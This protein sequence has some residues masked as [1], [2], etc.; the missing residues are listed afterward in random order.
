VTASK[1]YYIDSSCCNLHLISGLLASSIMSSSTKCQPATVQYWEPDN[2]RD[3]S[4]CGF[5][6]APPPKTITTKE[7]QLHDIRLEKIEPK[8]KTHGFQVIYHKSSLLGNGYSS[9]RF[10]DDNVENIYFPEVINLV[11]RELGPTQ[12]FIFNCGIR[13][14]PAPDTIV[15]TS[16]P[17]FKRDGPCGIPL[18]LDSWVLEK[19]IMPSV[20]PRVP[21][22]RF[23][24]IDY[25]A[26]GARAML[27]YARKD[28]HEA[29]IDIIAAEDAAAEQGNI[30]D[31]Q[32]RR[33]AFL[34]VWRPLETVLC[35]P[36]IVL[37]T[38][39]LVDPTKE[40]I[41]SVNKQPGID[42]PF[43]AGSYS[44]SA[45]YADQHRWLWVSE[46]KN[47]EVLLFSLFDSYAAREKRF[48]GTPH[49]SPKLKDVSPEIVRKSIEVRLVA[50]W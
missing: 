26:Q 3:P 42:G 25:S 18:N 19:P 20:A 48:P 27:R 39:T 9:E 29:A 12:V 36:L 23:S 49:V 15:L 43:L 24:H 10:I 13:K 8:L 28:V 30:D 40:L 32:G 38:K 17:T 22:A 14:V 35:D 44:L 41:E 47:D 33:Y 16:D 6:A 50:L 37:D 21:P 31:Y 1:N 45:R 5:F 7:V 2:Y 11:K 4:D 34:S 46:Q